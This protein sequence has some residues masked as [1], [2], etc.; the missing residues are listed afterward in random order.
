VEHV[1]LNALALATIA[2]RKRRSTFAFLIE[3]F[4]VSGREAIPAA[5]LDRDDWT[6]A[7]R[8]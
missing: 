8:D 3:N 1:V 5:A 4:Q 7:S 2:L 6:L